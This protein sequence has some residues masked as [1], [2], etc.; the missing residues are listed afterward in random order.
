[1]FFVAQSFN[2][3]RTTDA[4]KYTAY[5]IF[6]GLPPALRTITYS[7]WFN[8]ST[9]QSLYPDEMPRQTALSILNPL[10][11][12]ITDSLATYNILPPL[13]TL[14]EFLAPVLTNF[15]TQVTAA[16]PP[17][18]LTKDLATE[19]E[20]CDRS[21]VPLTYHHLIPREVHGKVLK[22]RWHTEDHLNDAA[23]VCRACHSI[24]FHLHKSVLAC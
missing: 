13:T 15:V 14:S 7:K 10:S 11:P 4:Q 16:P 12:S 17:P 2:E 23:W 6:N 9:L 1:M 8:S 22:R 3:R 5:E 21:W 20:I 24:S 19:C 18:R